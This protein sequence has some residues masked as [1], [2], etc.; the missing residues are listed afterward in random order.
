MGPGK[1]NQQI[2][3]HFSGS[4]ML[5]V[6]DHVYCSSEHFSGKLSGWDLL[7]DIAHVPAH[8]QQA[9]RSR[10]ILHR[11]YVLTHIDS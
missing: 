10:F 11:S 2:I 8:E 9:K 5:S 1:G 3:L 7:K 4:R 6:T